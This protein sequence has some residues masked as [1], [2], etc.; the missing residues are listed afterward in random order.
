[1]YNFEDELNKALEEIMDFY[2]C[3]N[4]IDALIRYSKDYE[5]EIRRQIYEDGGTEEDVQQTLEEEF[6]EFELGRM[7]DPEI[8]ASYN[9]LSVLIKKYPK[10]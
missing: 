2:G 1:M 10:D 6:S 7:S 5:E 8:A 9:K 3:D 4:P